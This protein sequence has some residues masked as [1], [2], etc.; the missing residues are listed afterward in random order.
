[1]ILHTFLYFPLFVDRHWSPA[2]SWIHLVKKLMSHAALAGCAPSAIIAASPSKAPDAVLRRWTDLLPRDLRSPLQAGREMWRPN[3]A[4]AKNITH[5]KYRKRWRQP[6]Q[7]VVCTCIP[8][9]FTVVSSRMCA[10]PALFCF[11]RNI[12]GEMT[13]KLMVFVSYLLCQRFLYSPGTPWHTNKKRN[14]GEIWCRCS[15]IGKQPL[16]FLDVSR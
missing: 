8:W 1:M 5:Y 13:L 16:G 7:F 6:C 9:G 3:T 12:L 10:S 2:S 11:V 15:S 4:F 14:R